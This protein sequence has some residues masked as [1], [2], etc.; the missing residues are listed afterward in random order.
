MVVT[1]VILHEGIE[2]I[3]AYAFCNLEI[4]NIT[5]PESVVWLGYD[6]ADG[7][8]DTLVLNPNCYNETE[9]EYLMR[10]ESENE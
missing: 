7:C 1:D 6:F 9:E 2:R 3:G 8:E 10:Y 4:E 5:V